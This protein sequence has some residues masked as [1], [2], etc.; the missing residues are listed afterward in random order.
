MVAAVVGAAA[1]QAFTVFKLLLKWLPL[2]IQGRR[3][4]YDWLEERFSKIHD[5]RFD[6]QAFPIGISI[7]SGLKVL[8]VGLGLV[9]A[10]EVIR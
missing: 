7:L 10:I 5:S 2:T 9:F 8:L 4:R 1:W 3:E 6:W